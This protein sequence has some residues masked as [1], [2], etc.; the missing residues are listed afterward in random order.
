MAPL[1][2]SFHLLIEDQDLILSAILVNLILISLCC[3]LGLC[4]SFKSCGLSLSFL[5]HQCI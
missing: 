1:G 2:M 4:Q 3:D 5:L